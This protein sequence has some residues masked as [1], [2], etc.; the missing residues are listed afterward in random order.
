MKVVFTPS[1]Q[2][3]LNLTIG[4]IYE[5]V[6]LDNKVGNEKSPTKDYYLIKNDKGH[7]Y[8]YYK[9]NFTELSVYRKNQIDKII[10]K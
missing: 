9:E 3:P 2:F 10:S 1:F 5:V 8:T 7:H 6:S 4:K